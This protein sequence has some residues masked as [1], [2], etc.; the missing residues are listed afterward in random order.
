MK[1]KYLGG[2]DNPS[3]EVNHTPVTWSSESP[4]REEEL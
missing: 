1:E 3:A 2:N 4:C